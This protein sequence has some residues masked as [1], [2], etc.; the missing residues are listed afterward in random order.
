MKRRSPI[1]SLLYTLIVVMVVFW[2]GNFIVGKLALREFP[3]LL[4]AGLRITLAGL[5]MLPV[6]WRGSARHQGPRWSRTD[7]PM[8]VLLGLF[9]VTLNQ[10]FFVLGLSR[11]SVAH[12]AIIIGADSDAGPADRGGHAV[13]SGSRRARRSGMADRASRASRS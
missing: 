12:S 7:V 11:T 4:V 6:Y 3:P 10:F 5:F 2:S 9:G 13:R 1:G 8:L